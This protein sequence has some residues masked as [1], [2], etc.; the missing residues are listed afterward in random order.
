MIILFLGISSLFISFM[1]M[2]LWSSVYHFSMTSFFLNLNLLF[3]YLIVK[4]LF[5]H[6]HVSIMLL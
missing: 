6:I 2:L 1:M 3:D 4:L 5:Y